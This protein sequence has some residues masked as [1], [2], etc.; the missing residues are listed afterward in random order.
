MVYNILVGLIVI[1]LLYW[2]YYR[3]FILDNPH[4][5]NDAWF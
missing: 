4:K 5:S 2:L 3:R 1:V